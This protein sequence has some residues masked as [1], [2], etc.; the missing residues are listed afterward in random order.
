MKTDGPLSRKER[1]TLLDVEM[2][3]WAGAAR[4]SAVEGLQ[5]LEKLDELTSGEAKQPQPVPQNRR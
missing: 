2:C 3:L 4:G 5:L 1:E